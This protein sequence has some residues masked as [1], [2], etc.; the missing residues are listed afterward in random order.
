[1]GEILGIGTSHYPGPMVPDSYMAAFLRRTLES[2]RVPDQLK[3]VQSWPRP[4][5]LEWGSD[6][7]A[8]A[9][10][11]HREQLMGAFRKIRAEIE[12]FRPDFIVVW[13]DDQ[14]ENFR[15][16]IIPPF[17]V[18]IFDQA[19]YT[20]LA[21]ID[22]WARTSQ[23]VW[24]EPPG[25]VFTVK[26]HV[27]GGRYLV[28][29][30]LEEDFDLPYAYTLRFARGLAHSFS[31]TLLYLDYDRL[32]FDHCLI[33]F[34]VNCYGSAVIRSR[35]GNAHLKAEGKDGP[36]PP[37]PSPRRCFEL[38][39]AVARLLRASPWR[40]VLMAT[41]S[42]SHAFLTEKN[43]WLYPDMESDLRR[44]E[45]LRDG[46]HGRWRELSLSQIEDAGQNEILNWVC[47]AGAMT[48]LKL[49]VNVVDYVESYIFNSNKCFAVFRP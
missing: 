16:D 46:G 37:A 10:G 41:S 21:G 43:H 13:G 28:S 7:G 38:G 23:N 32:G 12:A 25:K 6:E 5:Q 8:T 30:L 39:R 18:Y 26:G 33:P 4:M 31:Q 2:P 17:C 20:P 44:F 49:K 34:H 15:E 1:M 36:D 3:K 14:Y 29:R 48:E 19:Q 27:P 22:R 35:G 40:V 45:E 11:K 47:L 9:A 42:W 24:D